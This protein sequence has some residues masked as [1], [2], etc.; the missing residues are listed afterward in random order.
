M[1]RAEDLHSAGHGL[2]GGQALLQ[3]PVITPWSKPIPV[4]T[5]PLPCCCN[6]TSH[7]V[8]TLT[9]PVTA[10]SSIAVSSSGG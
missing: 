1:V 8:V 9:I 6:S 5:E 4:K 2:R 7:R 3:C 10:V